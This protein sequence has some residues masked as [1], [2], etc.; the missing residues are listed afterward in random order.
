MKQA[1]TAEERDLILSNAMTL[2]RVWLDFHR[3]LTFSI[4]YL[5][6]RDLPARLREKMR[7]KRIKITIE[8]ENWQPGLPQE[9]NDDEP[10]LTD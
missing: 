10:T 8:Y 6:S 2:G 5:Y 9:G 1:P 4:L 3:D 7:G